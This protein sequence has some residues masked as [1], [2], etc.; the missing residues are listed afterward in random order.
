[1]TGHAEAKRIE[2]VKAG[3][4]ATA[5]DF[6]IK[7]QDMNQC[8]QLNNGNDILDIFHKQRLYSFNG[9]SKLPFFNHRACIMIRFGLYNLV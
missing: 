6:N 1:M 3:I 8:I 2:L 4:I 9:G 5:N 7:Y